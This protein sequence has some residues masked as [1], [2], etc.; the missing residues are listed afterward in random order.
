MERTEHLSET[1]KVDGGC[2]D[3]G[4]RDRGCTRRILLKHL[5]PAFSLVAHVLIGFI[6]AAK[7]CFMLVEF[8]RFQFWWM[9]MLVKKGMRTLF[10]E[11][12]L[13]KSY[14][15]FVGVYIMAPAGFHPDLDVFPPMRG[16]M[17][18]IAS[19]HQA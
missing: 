7:V 9:G 8:G 5:F 16:V 19:L 1:R 13:K 2:V 4:E 14:S 18:C 12:V 15:S 17:L 3:I 11:I 10:V 6:G